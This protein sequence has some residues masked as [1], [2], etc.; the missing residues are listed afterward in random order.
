M[1][2][3]NPGPPRSRASRLRAGLAAL[4]IALAWTGCSHQLGPDLSI[5]VE[6]TTLVP[7]SDAAHASTL[8]CCRVEGTVTNTCSIP[9]GV[10][11]K[12]H[13]QSTSGSAGTAID[14]V[15]N[16]QPGATATFSAPGLVVACSAVTGITPDHKITGI[17]T[18]TGQP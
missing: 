5:D 14:W 8:C 18:G 6:G 13:G 16:L 4:A 11:L 17:Y 3:T 15:D 12:F 9:I 10:S 2:A 7:S 1:K